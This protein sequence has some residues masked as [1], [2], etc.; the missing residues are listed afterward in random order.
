M[1]TRKR[2]GG[3]C[4]PST[5][6]QNQEPGSQSAVANSRFVQ[7]GGMP[8]SAKPDPKPPENKPSSEISV[9]CCFQA[10]WK[11]LRA[12]F[13]LVVWHVFPQLEP[14]SAKIK[15]PGRRLD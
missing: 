5:C 1:T 2:R 7:T 6:R 10:D 12:A 11:Y 3:A 9:T 14:T 8:W 13:P 15:C 4:K